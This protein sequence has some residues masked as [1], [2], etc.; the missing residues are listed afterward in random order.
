M[1]EEQVVNELTK[2]KG[3]SK[4]AAIRLYR[5]G[6]NSVKSLGGSDPDE[7]SKVTGIPKKQLT[8]WIILSRA[9]ER[10]KFI[11]VDTAAAELSQLIQITIDDAK[12]LVSS[13]VMSIEDLAEE[14]AE[15]LAEDTG[16][17]ADVIDK[18]IRK[19]KEAKKLPVEKRK[20][21]VAPSVETSF[22]SKLSGAFFGKGDG[23]TSIYND[24]S[25]FGQS[26]IFV[27]LTSILLWFYLSMSQASIGGFSLA[28]LWENTQFS[29]LFTVGTLEITFYPLVLV[30][31]IILTVV[32]WLILG[33]IISSA[34]KLEFKNTS[35]VLGYSL[36]PGIFLSIVLIGKFLPEMRF[37]LFDV[38]GETI[39]LLTFML[40]IFGLWA[41]V[42]FVRSMAFSPTTTTTT[43]IT[44]EA[45]KMPFTQA[46]SEPAVE[47]VPQETRPSIPFAAPPIPS[48]RPPSPPP[49]QTTVLPTVKPPT[50]ARPVAAPSGP[51]NLESFGIINPNEL[52]A[53][54]T[55]GFYSSIDL[56]RANSKD[57]AERTGIQ[58]SKI[59]IWRIISD[60]LRIPGLDLQNAMVLAKSGVRSVKH[61]SKINEN[62]LR[63]QV[64]DTIS[65]EGI[66]TSI[67]ANMIAEWIAHAKSL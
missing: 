37:P 15:L 35:A 44:P 13:G 33:K 14:S 48:S 38:S 10:K 58:Q 16:L 42:T 8:T 9:Q 11:E 32:L 63:V 21:V 23:L 49:S 41:V 66:P 19:A 17:S 18:W 7:L 52:A 43:A 54:K 60:L 2:I 3:L 22:G 4:K 31:G 40:G 47:I 29:M 50:A 20:V 64:L 46:T 28:E 6:V 55:A 65:K 67:T 34:R 61:L 27:L 25:S 30:G 56:L 59:I 53:L 57:I 12:R 45:P 62:A 39:Y 51:V 36:A 24:S 1:A 5:A 26:F